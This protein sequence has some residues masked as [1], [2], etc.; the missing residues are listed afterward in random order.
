MLVDNAQQR[1]PRTFARTS[2]SQPHASPPPASDGVRFS[3]PQNH[4][5][6]QQSGLPNTSPKRKRP[7]LRAFLIA[8]LLL[9]LSALAI[10]G[11]IA[12][13]LYTNYNELK[14][15]I[16][17]VDALSGALD[18]NT[19]ADVT[20]IV[21]NDARSLDA[22]T[23]ILG[24][25][26]DTI[27]LLIHS[28]S[29]N[30]SLISIP[31]DTYVRIPDFIDDQGVFGIIGDHIGL[32]HNK[33]NASYSYGG[34]KLL[35]RTVELLTNLKVDH[36]TE[37]GFDGVEHLVNSV[38]GIN[39]C[40]DQPIDD[41]EY[42]GLIW[43]P[44]CQDVDGSKA[45]AFARMRYDDP[46]GDIGRAQRQHQVIDKSARK[47]VGIVKSG[48][49]FNLYNIPELIP[50]AKTMLGFVKFDP[51]TGLWQIKDMVER[52]QNAQAHATEENAIIPIENPL[53]F[54][55]VVG[56]IVEVDGD[57]VRKYLKGIASE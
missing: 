54:D 39:I 9:F 4:Q 17:Y 34:P 5:H 16:Q 38:G 1:M 18:D 12:H 27:M 14:E 28:P 36:Y 49:I 53:G 10:G 24:A 37:I 50:I 43:T 22:Q 29:G 45:L 52:F 23:D 8:L 13:Y 33:I 57:E 7:I 44:G 48:D 32:T 41:S 25:R 26:S 31:R 51:S 6:G 56:S 19:G 3:H 15:S 47:I 55:D 46:T 40:Y 30:D 20:L 2:A 42:T 35:V 21:G 11:Y